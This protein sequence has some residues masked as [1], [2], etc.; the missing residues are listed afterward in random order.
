MK[1]RNAVYFKAVL[2]VLLVLALAFPAAAARY[3]NLSVGNLTVERSLAVQGLLKAAANTTGKVFYV[4]SGTGL[5]AIGRGLEAT[6]PLATVDYAINQSRASKGDFIIVMPGHAESYTAA[7][8]F[9]AD[10]AGITILGLGDGAARPTFTFA[11][12]DATIAIGAASVT[13][14]NVRFLAGITDIVTGLSIEAG[15]DNFTL[16]GC[17]FPIPGT[18]TFEFLSAITL[19]SGANDAIFKYNVYRD[20]ATSAANYW[21]DASAGIVTGLKLI[22]NDIFGRFAAAAVYSNKVH[23]GMLLQDNVIGNTI[24]GQFAVEL[25]AAATG[26]A[27]DN[28]FYSDAIATVFDPGSLFC[29]GNLASV[30]INTAA[31]TIPVAGSLEAAVLVIDDLLDTEVPAL[32]SELLKVPKSDSNVTWNATALAS[33][34]AEVDTALNT[35]VPASP[36][37]GSLNDFL[38]KAGGGNTFDKSTDSLEAI[39]D[40]IDTNNTADQVDIDAILADTIS[41]SGGTLPAAPTAGSLARYVATGGTA[42][43]TEL[44][45]SKS[46]VDALGV[47]GV[48]ALTVG[49]GSLVGQSGQPFIVKSALASTAVVTGGVD[50]TAVA[51]GGDIFID[52]IIIVTAG[53]GL[54]TGTNFTLEK[55]A[56]GGVLTF[57]GETVAALGAQAYETLAT[58]SV[59]A[60]TGPVILESGQKIVAKCTIASCDGAGTITLYIKARRVAAGANLTT[61]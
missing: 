44:G 43:G 55:A 13:I 22:G 60:S 29:L 31:V 35:I 24:T 11:D 4:S 25:T 47:N 7:N 8:G 39:R 21:L 53:T 41:I 3:E 54:A 17:E 48:A 46:I 49:A 30:A 20:G 5:N 19:A 61:P 14:A 9:D 26:M 15:G 42:L 58:G 51:T 23:T 27:V 40:I 36:T 50:V 33:V 1:K 59:V 28:R 32:T 16:V 45:D 56:G 52:D 18:A 57:F 2:S 12:T 6:R 37:A 38:S 10:V 34:N